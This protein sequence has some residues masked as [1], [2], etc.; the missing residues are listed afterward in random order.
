MEESQEIL[1]NSL[2]K[3]GVPIPSE[4][5]SVEDLTPETFM[6]ICTHSLRII[7]NSESIPITS[8][9]SMTDRFKVCTDL[10]SSVKDLGYIGD[11]S[12]HKFLYPSEEDMYKLIR[13]LVGRLSE[14]SPTAVSPNT[15]DNDS[16]AMINI[17]NRRRSSVAA[18]DEGQD[19]HTK[20]EYL[21]LRTE[22]MVLNSIQY[23]E[24][25]IAADDANRGGNLISGNVG[26][27]V[28]ENGRSLTEDSQYSRNSA[29]G[30]VGVISQEDSR[31]KLEQ[32]QMSL[33]ENSSQTSDKT[34]VF[35]N[36]E[37]VI[38]DEETA[39][40]LELQQLEEQHDLLNA[41]VEM[42]CNEQNPVDSYIAQL[43]KQIDAKRQNLAELESKWKAIIKPLEEKKRNLEEALSAEQPESQEKYR[44]WKKLEQDVESVLSETEQREGELSKLSTEIEK[45]P[46]L[47]TRRSYIERI[48]EI[49]KNSRKQ[50]VDIER[51]LKETRELQL[52]SNM[53]QERLHRT[54]AVVDETLQRESKKNQV[55]E[56]AHN[57]LTAIHESF[58]EISEKILATDRA[59]REA[60]DLETKLSRIVAQSLNVG[61]L[62]ADLDAI[63]KENEYLQSRL[64]NP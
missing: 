40:S 25:D 5:F 19:L 28:M 20:V 41:A 10:A 37:N 33:R 30:E 50:D 13:F 7:S 3:S 62:E 56:Q 57:L 38:S 43:S 8:P 47:A 18:D 26:F 27:A 4:V 36:Q 17:E 32:A 53:I 55:G 29:G 61:K 48:K 2:A 52:E 21:K 46:K 64:G 59:R 23:A 51:I 1:L 39:K 31:H 11:M 58:E 34:E 35:P 45:L 49:T 22:A 44:K 6:S 16:N 42:A 12:F 63:R 9:D 15:K 54:Y 60:T 24:K 14:S